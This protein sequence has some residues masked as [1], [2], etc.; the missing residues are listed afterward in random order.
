M[1]PKLTPLSPLAIHFITFFAAQ[2]SN[3]DT[4]SETFA[5]FKVR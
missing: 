4:G 2:R 3:H 1:R 5:A